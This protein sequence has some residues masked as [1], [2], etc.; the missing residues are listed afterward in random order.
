MHARYSK[1][2]LIKARHL[3]SST[4]YHHNWVIEPCLFVLLN[5]SLKLNWSFPLPQYC[6]LISCLHYYNN[7][8]GFLGSGFIPLYL[9]HLW[10]MKTKLSFTMHIRHST[11]CLVVFTSLIPT[12]PHCVL[13]T[14]AKLKLPCNSKYALPLHVRSIIPF[15]PASSSPPL[16][17]S[18]CYI[19]THPL[20]QHSKDVSF[21]KADLMFSPHHSQNARLFAYSYGIY[22][23]ELRELCLFADTSELPLVCDLIHSCIL[24]CIAQ[25]LVHCAIN[26]YE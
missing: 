23:T 1:F 4:F 5:I 20:W 11:M 25:C 8:S 21:M 15:L 3:D 22:R 19:Q 14:L 6:L 9:Y 26:M 7:L 13:S 2:S 18:A 12:P 16:K 17:I 24:L 10:A